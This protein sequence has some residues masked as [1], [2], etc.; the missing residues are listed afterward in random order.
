MLTLYFHLTHSIRCP[1]DSAARAGRTTR[2]L[3]L[4]LT[5]DGQNI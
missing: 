3:P 2:P 1:S 4:S 5:P